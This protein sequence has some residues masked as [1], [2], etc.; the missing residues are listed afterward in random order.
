MGKGCLTIELLD[1]AAMASL[2]SVFSFVC[3]RSGPDGCSGWPVEMINLG[4]TRGWFIQANPLVLYANQ[5][6]IPCPHLGAKLHIGERFFQPHADEK[7][8]LQT[9]LEHFFDPHD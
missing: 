8:S 3:G 9:F 6:H 4:R 5:K 2:Q 7:L 1:H